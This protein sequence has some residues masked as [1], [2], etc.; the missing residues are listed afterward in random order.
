MMIHLR[1]VVIC[2]PLGTNMNL[3]PGHSHLTPDLA[4]TA[5]VTFTLL[6]ISASEVWRGILIEGCCNLS[7]CMAGQLVL[8]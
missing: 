4:R 2:G 3:A 1:E 5:T 7:M 6:L 8:M